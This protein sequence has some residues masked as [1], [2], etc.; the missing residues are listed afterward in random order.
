MSEFVP[1]RSCEIWRSVS[2]PHTIDG[3]IKKAIDELKE[4]ELNN[5]NITQEAFA[6]KL[7]DIEARVTKLERGTPPPPPPDGDWEDRIQINEALGNAG[8]IV[9]EIKGLSY[10]GNSHNPSTPGKDILLTLTRPPLDLGFQRYAIEFRKYAIPTTTGLIN[11]IKLKVSR[12][13]KAFENYMSYIP[14]WNPAVIY[15]M[16]L[17]WDTDSVEVYIMDGIVR[18]GLILYKDFE[19]SPTILILGANPK[20]SAPPGAKFR[21]IS[22]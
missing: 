17:I 12:D 8:E 4:K 3:R 18:L 10:E 5:I 15:K 22:Y 13:G 6:G 21:L 19:I 20:Y 11:E 7:L 1:K 14:D 16:G 2:I 9:F